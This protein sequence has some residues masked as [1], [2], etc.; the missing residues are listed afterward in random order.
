MSS[1]EVPQ[2]FQCQTTKSFLPFK[3]NAVFQGTGT[4]GNIPVQWNPGAAMQTKERQGCAQN[5][6]ARKTK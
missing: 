5:K 3:E 6:R 2:V 4:L 1:V